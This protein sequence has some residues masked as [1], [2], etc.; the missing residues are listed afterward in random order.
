LIAD[1][2]ISD[3]GGKGLNQA[4]IAGRCDMPVRLIAPVGHDDVGRR[5]RALVAA[6]PFEAIL[7][8]KEGATDQSIIAVAYNGE[9][10]I[11]SSAFAA[12]A[13]TEDD[14]VTVA[15]DAGSTDRILM[16]G[17]LSQETTFALLAWAHD[18]G[19]ETT[20]NPSPIRWAYGQMWPL[21][22]RLVLN[23]HELATLSGHADLDRGL[24]DLAS[25]GVREIIVTR[26]GDGAVFASG[27]V[28]HGV[29]AAPANV[30]DT[31]GAG[32]TF[33]GV[34]MAALHKG[35]DHVTAMKIAA[36][37][38]AITIGRNGTWSA[39]PSA[40][41]LSDLFAASDPEASV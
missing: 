13:L 15:G 22:D 14:V 11:I 5:T 39:F 40:K 18:R 8:E 41:E 34:F 6:E 20:I 28:R 29:A 26:G 37:A 12:S 35:H 24:D 36:R 21:I 2:R 38:A 30:V 3:I 31:A 4:L 7:I 33:C 1:S 17:N 19:I 32:D 25:R 10:H 27:Q 23:S 16:Q 9:N